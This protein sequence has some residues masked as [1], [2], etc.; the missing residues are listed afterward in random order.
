MS[1]IV[2]VG[3]IVHRE[4]ASLRS[5]ERRPEEFMA[6]Y[7]VGRMLNESSPALYD[8][9][10][11]LE[12]YDRLFP[13]EARGAPLYAHAPF[14]ALLFRPFPYLPFKSALV[15]WHIVSI[16]LSP[17]GFVLPWR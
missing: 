17:A 4:V 7:T 10:A 1:V 6:F 12:A 3:A 14:E 5:A 15:A 9:T 13:R 8:S 11:F 2:I 16:V